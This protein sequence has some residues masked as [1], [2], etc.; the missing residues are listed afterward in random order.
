MN[1]S[2]K[3]HILSFRNVTMAAICN[4]SRKLNPAIDF[5]DATNRG[6]CPAISAKSDMIKFWIFSRSP[7]V[8]L[9]TCL[10]K[11]L[12][13]VTLVIWGTAIGFLYPNFF[14]IAGIISF[15]YFSFSLSIILGVVTNMQIRSNIQILPIYESCHF[16]VIGIF[17]KFVYYRKFV[18]TLTL[19]IGTFY[20]SCF[21][22]LP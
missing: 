1:L 2:K 7:E 21:F 14:C 20:K 18:I 13:S 12:F 11:E 8:L 15:L 19:L 22:Y 4:P 16:C 9:T 10:P 3:S 17:V 5:F 6:F